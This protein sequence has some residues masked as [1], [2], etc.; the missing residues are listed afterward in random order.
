MAND[1]IWQEP[2]HKAFMDSMKTFEYL[3]YRGSYTPAAGE[4]YNLRLIN[5]MFEDIIV[6][7]KSIEEAIASFEQ[8]VSNILTKSID[9]LL[10]GE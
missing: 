7:G 9:D 8:E 6:N 2:N 4:I 5:T 3:G 1:P 10:S